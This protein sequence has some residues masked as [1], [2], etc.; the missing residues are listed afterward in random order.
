MGIPYLT[1]NLSNYAIP[2][3]LGCNEEDCAT[4]LPGNNGFRTRV[5][6]D[7][8]SFA[9]AMYDRLVTNKPDLDA[10][11]VIPSYDEIG[12]AILSFLGELEK[13]NLIMYESPLFLFFSATTY[14]LRKVSVQ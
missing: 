3:I 7:G 5:V 14:I 6:V 12:K 9:Y 13:C 2:T 1:S 11:G 4:H 10:F 8:P